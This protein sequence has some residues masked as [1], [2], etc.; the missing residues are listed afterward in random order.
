MCIVCA[1][2]LR[3]HS[4]RQDRRGEKEAEGE[5]RKTTTEKNDHVRV[6]ESEICINKCVLYSVYTRTHIHRYVYIRCGSPH[7]YYYNIV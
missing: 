7:L 4:T 6:M 1:C 5:R 2:R 3:L